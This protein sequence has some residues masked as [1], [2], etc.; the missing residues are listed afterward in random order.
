MSKAEFSRSEIRELLTELGRRLHAR[1]VEADI[2][3][4]GGAAMALEFDERRVTADVD[5]I[6]THGEIS[7]AAA[8]MAEERGLPADWLNARAA[9]FLPGGADPGSVQFA[10]DGLTVSVASPQH[11]LAMKMAA[12]RPGKDYDDLEALFD[13]LGI[14]TPEQAA[15]LALSIY[16]EGTV[17]LPDRDELILSARAILDRRRRTGRPR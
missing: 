1:G 8:Q 14:E 5:G 10:C 9:M 7:R 12:F 17:V 15:D 16:G 2:Y 4:V 6:F 11:V 13:R 3:I